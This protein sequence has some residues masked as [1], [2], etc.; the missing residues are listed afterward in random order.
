MLSIKIFHSSSVVIKLVVVIVSWKVLTQEVQ[1]QVDQRIVGRWIDEEESKGRWV[2][3][4]GSMSKSRVNLPWWRL[5]V[6]S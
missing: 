3:E 5:I 2:D 4:R 1:N 6:G